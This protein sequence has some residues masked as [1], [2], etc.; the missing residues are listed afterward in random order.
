MLCLVALAAGCG[1]AA[2]PAQF[3]SGY[4]AARGPLNQTFGEVNRSLAA[5]RGK[6]ST[7]IAAGV[8][9]LAVRFAN[10]LAPLEALTPPARV[11]IAFTTLKASLRRVAADLRG[12]ASAARRRDLA[13]AQ[14]AV[15]NLASDAHSASLAAAAVKQKLYAS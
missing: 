10:Q 8:G 9:A 7:E 6:S 4:A 12:I 3:A 1:S 11:A 5:A 2:T 14:L 13:G 15:E